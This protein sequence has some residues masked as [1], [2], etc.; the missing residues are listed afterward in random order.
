MICD[1]FFMEEMMK[2]KESVYGK[3]ACEYDI[4]QLADI[5]F[6]RVFWNLQGLQVMENIDREIRN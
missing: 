3:A 2:G 4:K 5:H 6:D 1:D